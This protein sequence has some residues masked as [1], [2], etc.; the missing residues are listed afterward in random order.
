M[1]GNSKV[2]TGLME[3]RA[4]EAAF[5]ALVGATSVE[6]V[7]DHADA[8]AG[9]GSTALP[10]LLT[11]LDTDDPRLSAV[12]AAGCQKGSTERQSSPPECGLLT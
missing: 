12:A 2:L 6:E 10:G 5:A 7:A 3:R 4:L 9:Y 8:I 1:S 11:R